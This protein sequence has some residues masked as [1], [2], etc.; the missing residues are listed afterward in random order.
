MK[1][2]KKTVETL[3][4]VTALFACAM[5]M[6]V[7]AASSVQVTGGKAA[8]GKYCAT[9]K[10]T[11]SGERYCTLSI[12]QSNQLSGSRAYVTSGGKCL[13]KNGLYTI[14]SQIKQNYAFAY[15]YVY[16]SASPSSGVG[17]S[18]VIRIK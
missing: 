10:N 18:K 9:L 4:V 6:T 3:I 14:G 17:A 15:G 16:N 8:G 12:Y 13:K 7:F 11:S 5:G 1:S 2:I